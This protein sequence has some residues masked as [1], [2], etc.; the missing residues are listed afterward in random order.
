MTEVALMPS[1]GVMAKAF[2]YLAA[3]TRS[4]PSSTSTLTISSPSNSRVTPQ[5]HTNAAAARPAATT[6]SAPMKLP[7][8]S[9]AS[10]FNDINATTLDPRP[11]CRRRPAQIFVLHR[12]SERG[13]AIRHGADNS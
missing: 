9:R 4:R 1:K 2:R 7:L 6:K 8:P 10:S 13:V 3:A 11:D 5:R 12:A